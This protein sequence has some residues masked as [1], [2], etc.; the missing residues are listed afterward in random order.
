M[1]KIN[2]VYLFD[3]NYLIKMK[4]DLDFLKNS[5]ISTFYEIECEESDPF[6][7]FINFKNPELEKKHFIRVSEDMLNSIRQGQFLILQDLIFYHI[8]NIN[9]KKTSNYV[10]NNKNARSV[11]PKN[12]NNKNL[13]IDNTNFK[14]AVEHIVKL[15]SPPKNLTTKK[16]DVR[17]HSSK[18]MRKSKNILIF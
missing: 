4:Y 11:S 18:L 12:F 14:K 17:P 7:I 13:Y 3:R 6:L 16:P 15:Y 2:K 8:Y 5:K 10:N 9:S 1:E